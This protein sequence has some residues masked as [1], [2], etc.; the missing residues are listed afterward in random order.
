M[1]VKR[2]RIKKMTISL[3]MLT[4]ISD[5]S[6]SATSLIGNTETAV[7][8]VSRE[9]VRQLYLMKKRRLYGGVTIKIFQYPSEDKNH[10]N[11]VNEVLAMSMEKYNQEWDKAVNAGLSKHISIVKSRREMLEMISKTYNGVGYIDE[12]TLIINTGLYN[13]KEIR[14]ID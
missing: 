2:N 9:E 4:L 11:F 12:D 14:I 6:H 1:K 8:T 5:F 13:V 7:F 10:I 3:L